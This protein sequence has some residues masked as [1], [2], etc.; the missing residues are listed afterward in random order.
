[1]ILETEHFTSRLLGQTLAESSIQS[2]PK[3]GFGT[4]CRKAAH[5]PRLV[6]SILAYLGA[7]GQLIDTAF[8]YKN[9]ADVAQALDQSNLDRAEIWITDKLLPS[10]MSFHEAKKAVDLSC[11]QLGVKYVDLML[12][13]LPI[14]QGCKG[15]E[16]RKLRV[17][18]W[19]ALIEARKAGK[20]KHIGVSNFNQSQIDELITATGVVPENNQIEFSP[21]SPAGVGELVAWMQNRGISVTAYGSLGHSKNDLLGTGTEALQRKYG[22]VTAQILLRW[23]LDK[24]VWVVPGA[25]TAHHIE[26]NLSIMDFHLSPAELDSLGVEKPPAWQHF[27]P[28]PGA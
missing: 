6:K 7:G 8:M 18:T 5:G 3:I 15:E 26:E 14:G 9:H 19:N 4:C 11:R 1:M 13:H 20:V 12:I 16:C 24:K 28:N 21:F 17:E 2:M 10:Q 27:H 23:A 25:T 22:K